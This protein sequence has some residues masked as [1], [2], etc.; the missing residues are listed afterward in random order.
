M[1]LNKHQDNRLARDQRVLALLK[2][3]TALFVKVPRLVEVT[4]ELETVIGSITR[5]AGVKDSATSG[6]AEAKNNAETDLVNSLMKVGGSL[7]SLARLDKDASMKEQASLRRSRLS[8]MRAPQLSIKAESIFELAT[9]NAEKLTAHGTSAESL[10]ALRSKI[11]AFDEA[12]GMQ[13]TGMAKQVGAT[14]N[15]PDLFKDADE[16]LHEEINGLV[17]NLRDDYPDFYAQYNSAKEIK[18]LGLRHNPPP[19]DPEKPPET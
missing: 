13:G 18:D 10:A 4:T 17:E 5:L 14:E 3:N 7:R 12:V 19:D 1:Q 2:K 15:L 6:T 8:R 9:A 16:I 11:D